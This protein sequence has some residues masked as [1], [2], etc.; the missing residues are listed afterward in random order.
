VVSDRA[1][2]RVLLWCLGMLLCSLAVLVGA[3]CQLDRYW[4]GLAVFLV[5]MVFSTKCILP[6]LKAGV[7]GCSMV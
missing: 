6:V 2:E 1:T 5:V 7:S 3:D 4:V